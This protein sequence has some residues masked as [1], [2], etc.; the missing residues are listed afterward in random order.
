MPVLF[1]PLTPQYT[2]EE[3]QDAVGA[4]V[5]DTATINVTYTDAT[6]E[7]KWDVIDGSVTVA[8]LATAAKT[9]ALPLIIDGGAAVITTGIKCD[10]HFDA[11][12]TIVAATLLADQ[13]GSIV[14]DL[15]KDTY[16]NFPPTVAATITASAKPTITTATKS[17]DTTLT[18]WTTS[19]SAGDVLRVNV[20]SVTSIQR[21]TLSL[22]LVRA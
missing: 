4:M 16:A 18:G 22:K 5:V 11:A 10:I 14:I 21:V 2:T 7:L 19:V 8:K 17:Q 6:P 20:D 13:S 9:V 12:Y 1:P 15:W 3:A